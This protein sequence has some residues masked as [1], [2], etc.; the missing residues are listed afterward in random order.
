MPLSEH[1][2][3]VLEQME[4][5]LYAE[6]PRF[7]NQ[8]VGKAEAKAARRR[9]GVGILAAILGLGL[10][11]LGVTVQQIWVGGIGFAA[12]VLGAALAFTPPR[13]SQ[14]PTLGTVQDDGNITLRTGSSNAGHGGRTHRG[15]GGRTKGSGNF[16]ER[17]EQRWDRRR[18]QGPF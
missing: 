3:R 6:D 9:M 17:L 2:Q 18:E 8:M 11:V 1:E 10:I 16:M 14:G 4:Q 12:M 15:K 13:K 5:A 7:A